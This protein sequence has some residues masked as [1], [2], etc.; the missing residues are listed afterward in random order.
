MATAAVPELPR[1]YLDSSYPP[2]TGRTLNVPAG[3]DLQF[4]LDSAQPGDVVALQPGATFTGPFTLPKKSGVGWI[5][6]RSAAPDASLPPAGVR[7]TP[8]F[9]PVLPKIVSPDVGPALLTEP[10]AHHYRLVALE[11]AVAPPVTFNYGLV[12]LGDGSSAQSSASDVPHDLVLDRVY[13]HGRPMGDLRRG[14][15]LNSAATAVVDSYIADI[16]EVG[17]DSQAIAGWNG[18]GPF[19]IVNNYLEGAGENVLFGGADP[20]ITGLV[21]SDIEIRANHLFKPLSWRIEEPVYSGMPWSVKNLLE[22]KNARRVLI[23][24]NLI[25]NNWLHS[26]NGFAVLFTVRNQDGSASWSAVQDVT[27]VRNIVR[28]TAAGVNV[29]GRDNIFPSQQTQRILIAGNLFDDVDG[30]RWGG[31]GRLFQLLDGAREVV[32]EH[33][34]A[35]HDGDVAMASGVPLLGFVYRNNLTANNDYGI[36]GDGT[37]GN[38]LLTLSTYFP[39]AVFLANALVGGNLLSYPP[40]NFFPAR[41]EDVG[42]VDW[43]G[44]NYRLR[45]TSPFHGAGTDGVDIGADI[46]AILAAMNGASG[47]GGGSGDTTPPV[48]SGVTAASLTVSGAAILWSTNEP[49][50]SLVRYG[51]TPGYGASSPLEGSLSVA[52]SVALG[53]LQADTLY[54][55]RVES[56]DAAGNLSVSRD[57]TFTTLAAGDVT[58]PVVGVTAP[59]AG[60][61]VSGT[62]TVSAQATDDVAVAGVRFELDGGALGIEEAQPPFETSWGST[63]TIDGPHTLRAVAR[64]AA[65]N[66]ATSSVTVTV[67]NDPAG[68]ESVTWTSRKNVTALSGVLQKT[69]GCDGCQD[70]GAVSVESLSSGDGFLE[71]VAS[72]TST[73][74]VV[75]ISHGNNDTSIAD[76]DFALLFWPGGTVDVRENGLYR[77]AETAYAPGDVFRISIEAGEVTYSKNGVLFYGSTVTPVYPLLVDSALLTIGATLDSVTL[78]AAQ[79]PRSPYGGAPWPIPGR[80]EAENF[81]AGGEG[82]TYHDWSAG[83][84]GGLYRTDEA[85][86]IISPYTGGYVVNN[87]QSDEWLEYTLRQATTSRVE[88]DLLVS[89]EFDGTSFRVEVDGVDQT[90]AVIVPRTG[91]WRTF[92]WVRAGSLMMVAGDHVLRVRAVNQ[93]FNFDALRIQSI[94]SGLV[95]TDLVNATASGDGA[96]IQKSSGCDGCPDA[97][98]A[99]TTA[100]SADGLLE[101]TASETDTQR[102]IGLSHGNAD[103]SRADIDFALQFWPGGTVDVRENGAYRN[104]ETSYAPGDVFRIAVES[105]IVDYY[106]NGALFYRSG[107]APT[108]PLCVDTALFDVGATI[109]G[110]RVSGASP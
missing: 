11:I 46:D 87:F 7:V 96:A 37:F 85:V 30:A 105:G 2:A 71:L 82:V 81:D 61:T 69:S 31:S 73:Q 100:L 109:Q 8:D 13:I 101:L 1:V 10:G 49:S 74:R 50:D 41:W 104:A 79:D 25:E 106:K 9:A 56:R 34:T 59:L 62:L 16:H 17:A 47:G 92:A 94:Q 91:S 23:E 42:F 64:D 33:N 76:I 24:G 3:G 52:H 36:A 29:L 108:F 107:V 83:N 12:L 99:T 89:T 43:N 97:G 15:A 67:K 95:W 72:E 84:S 4:A 20:S 80:I 68:G 63:A 57:F 32:I 39:G 55:Y 103:T 102:V 78:H 53:G 38:P 88:I 66:I 14:V 26:Q 21:P 90:G 44:G 22:L 18:P 65:G 28:H 19:K 35:F 48:I 54:H 86:D 70:A 5:V 60:S 75:G 27:F 77:N 98:G 40:G 51:L 110:I 45:V 93:Y 6:V 58:P